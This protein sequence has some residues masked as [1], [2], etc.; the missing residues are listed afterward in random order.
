MTR[1]LIIPLALLLML[2]GAGPRGRGAPDE[3]R[4][5]RAQP[6]ARG[7]RRRGGVRVG[8]P[9][10]AA[11]E[12][13]DRQGRRGGRPHRAGGAE[14]PGAVLPRPRRV[15]AVLPTGRA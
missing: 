9:E 14:E 3:G 5:G 11:A 13:G 6:D 12:G 7:R 10:G 4:A 8:V 15:P 1:I 2:I